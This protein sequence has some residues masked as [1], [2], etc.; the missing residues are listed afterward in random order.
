M[1]ARLRLRAAD[2]E[3]LIADAQLTHHH[4]ARRVRIT[5]NR[6][7][8]NRNEQAQDVAGT[9]RAVNPTP[10]A[11]QQGDLAAMAANTPGALRP[12][13]TATVG[14]LG[15]R[16]APP[17]QHHAQR[18]ELLRLRPPARRVVRRRQLVAVRRPRGAVAATSTQFALGT[19]YP[20]HNSLTLMPALQWTDCCRRARSAVRQYLARRI[21]RPIRFNAAL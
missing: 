19:N 7:R 6:N 1:P 12:G 18:A 15:A 10:A 16:A 4:D 2:E 3:I 13:H 21:A 17:E 5:A 20:P 8:A 9:E 14:L 11:S